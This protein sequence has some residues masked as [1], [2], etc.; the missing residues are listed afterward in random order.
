MTDLEQAYAEL[1]ILLEERFGISQRAGYIMMHGSDDPEESVRLHRESSRSDKK[2]LAVRRRI[3]E[4]GGT[5]DDDD[6]E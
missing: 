2:V 5:L 1:E 3:L 6:D 4:L